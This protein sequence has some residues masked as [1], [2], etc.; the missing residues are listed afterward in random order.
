MHVNRLSYIIKVGA[1]L[2]KWKKYTVRSK[3]RWYRLKELISTEDQ[4]F[5]DL[6][7]IKDRIKEP[8]IKNEV[9]TEELAREMFPSI[10]G[11]IGL[12]VELQKDLKSKI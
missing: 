1:A 4:Y 5:K 8:L 9:I 7:C 11:M 2:K 6:N 3:D 12:S 10:E